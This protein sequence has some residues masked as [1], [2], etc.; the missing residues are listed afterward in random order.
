MINCR[1][2]IRTHLGTGG[3]GDVFLVDDIVTGESVA[4]KAFVSHQEHGD[5]KLQRQEFCRLSA[6]THRNLIRVFDFGVIR[7]ADEANLM[8]RSYLTMEHVSGKDALAHF[9]ETPGKGDT[10]SQ[11]ESLLV[12]SLCVLVYIHEE[13]LIHCDL[14]P[15]N[16]LVIGSGNSVS[17]KLTDF[18]F[19][20]STLDA[21][22][23]PVQGTFE[24][25]APE[26]IQGAAP[27]RRADLFA[28]G[29]T[30]FHLLEGRCPFESTNSIDLLRQILERDLPPFQ[31][32]G[33]SGSKI[34]TVIR[35][36]CQRE[37][38]N[39]YATAK[40]ALQEFASSRFEEEIKRGL[41]SDRGIHFV[42]REKELKILDRSLK[43]VGN[44]GQLNA[45]MVLG[46]SGIGKTE[47]LRRGVRIAQAE[48]LQILQLQEQWRGF[49]LAQPL[50]QLGAALQAAGIHS[51]IAVD[52]DADQVSTADT[53]AAQLI[54]ASLNLPFLLVLDDVDTLDPLSA[55]IVRALLDHAGTGRFFVLASM[56]TDLLNEPP[57]PADSVVT[58]L[59]SEFAID[60]L[61]EFFN[62]SIG[63]SFSDGAFP[64]QFHLHY[65][66]SPS[67]AV[68]AARSVANA[69]PFGVLNNPVALEERRSEIDD[70]IA[71]QFEEYFAERFRMLRREKQLILQLISCFDHPP[72]VALLKRIIPFE[73]TRLE[74][75]LLSLE[76]EGFVASAENNGRYRIRHLSLK[77]LVYATNDDRSA[78]H[79]FLATEMERMGGDLE[80]GDVAELAAQYARSEEMRKAA[81]F[82]ELSGENA[83]VAADFLAATESFRKSFQ[84]IPAEMREERFRVGIKLARMLFKT[85]ADRECVDVCGKCLDGHAIA[86]QMHQELLTISGKSYLRLGENVEALACFER[87]LEV[88]NDESERFDLR[89][90][91]I[92]LKI[93]EGNYD[94]AI[95][96]GEQQKGMASGQTNRKQLAAVETDLGIAYFF[97]AQYKESLLCFHAALKIYT[98]DD[99]TAKV[100][101][102]LNNIGNVLSAMRDYRGALEKWNQAL[103]LISDRGTDY[104][105]GQ[106]LNNIGIAY[107]HLREYGEAQTHYHQSRDIFSQLNSRSGIAY[108]LTNLG[109]VSTAQGSYEQALVYWRDALE[110]Y[111]TMQDSCGVAQTLL[112]SAQ[113]YLSLGEI[114]GAGEMIGQA[115]RLTKEYRLLTL[116]PLLHYLRG[117]FLAGNRNFQAAVREFEK[118]R[119]EFQDGGAFTGGCESVEEKEC[120]AILRTVEIHIVRN[121]F[122]SAATI[123]KSLDTHPGKS[124]SPFLEAEQCYLLGLIARAH[125]GL[126]EDKPLMYFRRGLS[127][128]EA[129]YVSEISWKLSYRLGCEYAQRGNRERAREYLL[130]AKV[131]L[132]YFLSKFTITH[133]RKQYLQQDG[134]ATVLGDIS[135][136]K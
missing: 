122:T 2:K 55:G 108:A 106:I 133:L 100:I 49:A 111:R 12:Q 33:A 131:V 101:D 29:I 6:L 125:P 42:G 18:G 135:M 73:R 21:T 51:E 72:P 4:L 31:H 40:A 45:L 80:T 25:L 85:G 41:F 8:G 69:I 1:Y 112:Q 44:G 86:D 107:F 71:F 20:R 99:D 61:R 114:A 53:Y 3:S 52:P 93:S 113:L 11:L 105:R 54:H 90:E 22:E 94:D 64:E 96:L 132:E 24:Y 83:S 118:A 50:R 79:R 27:D 58:M 63:H 117:I 119:A 98:Q 130:N 9:I 35:R 14:K 48:G 134:R 38:A 65:G 66:G 104:Q 120:A 13:G 34:S 115:E 82:Y 89:Q 59:L 124:Q 10:I 87:A 43:G 116:E 23:G 28:L 136:F 67:I 36:L 17:L 15:Q 123:L 103:G 102:A 92:G 109:E 56:S 129:E 47:F 127:L 30:F 26:V 128:V 81:Q 5:G 75:F 60:N 88:V 68:E 126:L 70:F 57:F 121:E 74:H 84:L 16:L 76:S 110:I 37:P 46:A 39:R 7:S 91:I 97:K 32:P 19:S 95:T 78:L 62:W 77:Q